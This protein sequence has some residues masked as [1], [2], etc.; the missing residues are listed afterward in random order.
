MKNFRKIAIILLSLVI[1]S[2]LAV[3]FSRDEVRFVIKTLMNDRSHSYQ[4]QEI[5][6]SDIDSEYVPI[7]NLKYGRRCTFDQSLMLVNKS[8]PLP[9]NFEAELEQY[10]DTDALINECAVNAFIEMREHISGRFSERLL[11]MSA[12]RSSEEQL[13]IYNEDNDGVAAK[14]GFSE[15]ETG[16]GIDVYVKYYAGTGFIK[17][18][19]G[20]YVNENCGEYGFIIR[21]PLGKKD[22]TGFS[23]E[24]WH[25]RY[26]GLPH[27]QIIM[28]NSLTLE[29]YI[30]SLETDCYYSYGN[31]IIS[32]QDGDGI[33]V[34]EKYD[35][36][37]ISPDNLGNYIV[38]VKI[39]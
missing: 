8:S 26:V 1:V 18:E 7:K 16:L 13:E 12:Y 3:F 27:S 15:H 2:S 17:S 10:E 20:Q 37:V 25:L 31:Y 9:E 38:T 29:D 35:S 32:K 11:I 6:I 5:E 34:P 23:Y 22:I 4:L 19:I 24:P 39:R 14:P 36:I 33:I 30:K 28:Q 21:Y